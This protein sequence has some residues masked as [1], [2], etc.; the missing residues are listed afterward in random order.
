MPAGCVS[1]CL[2]DTIPSLLDEK[3]DSYT[4]QHIPILKRH[5]NT[6]GSTC[7][8]DSPLGRLIGDTSVF[9]VKYW[10]WWQLIA[11]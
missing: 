3:G 4:D 11:V 2:G 10:K 8:A 1:V 5:Q 6:T 7:D 9:V